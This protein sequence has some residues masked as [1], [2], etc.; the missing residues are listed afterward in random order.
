V[1]LFS[2]SAKAHIITKMFWMSVA[3]PS[4]GHLI[5]INKLPQ[6]IRCLLHISIGKSKNLYSV[7]MLNTKSEKCHLFLFLLKHLIIES[8]LRHS[9][10]IPCITL[11]HYF[12]FGVILW[13]LNYVHL[14]E[15]CN[16][17]KQ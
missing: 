9:D 6:T 4:S 16:K 12:R 8:D 13:S 15:K 14:V 5:K 11:L 3:P 17:I 1:S 7:F 2:P 10:E